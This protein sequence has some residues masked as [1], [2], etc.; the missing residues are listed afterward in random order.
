MRTLRTR[1]S[2]LAC[3]LIAVNFSSL[4]SQTLDN[5][6]Q[7][8][9]EIARNAEL[10]QQ[11]KELV[12]ET[13]SVKA[14]LSLE[15]AAK[16]HQ[17]SVMLLNTVTT[18][19]NLR[20]VALVARKAREAILQTI[21]L[22]KREAKLE[23]SAGKA[24]ERARNRLEQAR[25][26][27][28]ER[29]ARDAVAARK[30]TEEAHSQLQRSYDNMREHLYEVSLRLAVSS[31]QFS[32]RAI[33]IIRRDFSDAESVERAIA[34]TERIIERGREH[35]KIEENQRLRRMLQEALQ[36]QTKAKQS[37]RAGRPVM[38]LDLTEQARRIA[39]R[40]LK[41]SASK[42]NSE[43]VEQA[44]RLTDALL[45]EARE[46]ARERDLKELFERIE[47]AE[48]LHKQS[49]HQFDKGDHERALGLTVRAREILKKSLA[50]IRTE[51]KQDGVESALKKTDE[52]L[53]RLREAVEQSRDELAAE[54]LS[55]AQTKQDKAWQNF[56][57]ARLRAALANTRLARKLANRAFEQLRYEDI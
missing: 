18:D 45:Q 22:A 17:H 42:A 21:A 41:A 7:L 35:I 16:L 56:R 15:A 53:G 6:A 14:R 44:I 38:A 28:N 8:R 48:Q 50:S 39:M 12:S 34:K 26:L 32:S 47:K 36:L 49:K 10:L 1:I 20:D 54:L 19:S 52:I 27:I 29:D 43:N 51:P 2:L 9:E 25:Q 31:E 4:S 40:V 37:Y 30:L 57:Q 46:V 24:I 13:S 23:E 55:R 33:T 5:L 11:A 3:F